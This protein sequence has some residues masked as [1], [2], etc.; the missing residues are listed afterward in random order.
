M[1]LIPEATP[2]YPAEPWD[3]H[4]HAVFG[5][6]LVPKDQAPAPH[7]PHTKAITIF[8][9][10]IVAAAFFIYEQPSALT[11]D[12]IMSTVLVRDGFKPRVSITHIWVNSPGSRD[13]GRNLWAIPKQLADFTVTPGSSY[14]AHEIGTLRV[15]RAVHLP[16][17]LPIG[18]T[19]AQ[20]RNGTL[21]VTPVKGRVKLGIAMTRWAFNPTGPL[22]HLTQKRPLIALSVKRFRLTFGSR[23]S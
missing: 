14:E 8:G 16:I 19:T 23:T 9:R 2:Y 3:L 10:H 7:S 22:S 21:K 12:E 1:A 4:G 13:G 17:K 11:Y 6:W 18:F 15:R 20:D 5:I